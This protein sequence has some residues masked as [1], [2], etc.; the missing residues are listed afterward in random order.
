M[1]FT[2]RLADFIFF[3]WKNIRII[4]VYD[5]LHLMVQHPFHDGTGTRCTASMKQNT[6]HANRYFYD[7]CSFHGDKSIKNCRYLHK[8]VEKS[9]VQSSY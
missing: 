2:F 6:M 8:N 1:T 9:Y 3:L 4:I 7:T 5:R